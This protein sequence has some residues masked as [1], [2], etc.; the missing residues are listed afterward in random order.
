MKPDAMEKL[1][2]LFRYVEPKE[3]PAFLSTLRKV[4]VTTSTVRSL[5]RA[6]R[7]YKEKLRLQISS[8]PHCVEKQVIN[9]G[10]VDGVRTIRESLTSSHG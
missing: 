2:E 4:G 10:T 1:Q 5:S 9:M 6:Y 7:N 3:I 8:V